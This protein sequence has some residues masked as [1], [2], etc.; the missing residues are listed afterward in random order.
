MSPPGAEITENHVLVSQELLSGLQ[1]AA[2]LPHCHGLLIL[3]VCFLK[4]TLLLLSVGFQ[5]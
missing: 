4:Y 1:V 2:T 5:I 3:L